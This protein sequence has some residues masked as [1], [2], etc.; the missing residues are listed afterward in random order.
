VRFIYNINDKIFILRYYSMDPAPPFEESAQARRT[1][2]LL[3]ILYIFLIKASLLTALS[4]PFGESAQA[5]RTS[6]LYL[7]C[8]YF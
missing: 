4:A 2:S 8:I 5:R 6:S 1:S 7:C 3:F